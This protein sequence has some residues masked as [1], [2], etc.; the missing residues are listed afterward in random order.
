MVEKLRFRWSR[1]QCSAE[2]EKRFH[3]SVGLGF[4]IGLGLGYDSGYWLGLRFG[5]AFG[6]E[7]RAQ[8]L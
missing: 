5:P 3:F 6:S 8:G 4:G 1:D 7:I 2:R